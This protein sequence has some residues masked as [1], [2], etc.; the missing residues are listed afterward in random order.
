ML[1]AV[2]V[3]MDSIMKPVFGTP[4]GTG[5]GPIGGI[6]TQTPTAK[7]FGILRV[8]LVLVD[9]DEAARI[10]Q[11]LDAAHRLMPR[12]AGSIIEIAEGQFLLALRLA[13]LVDLL[14][15]I[16]PASTFLTRALVIHLMCL[17]RISTFQQPLGVAHAVQP[18]VADVGLGRDEG[19]RH[20]VAHL[21]RGAGRFPG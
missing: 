18:Q 21:A 20:A 12:K 14:D 11:P 16:V 7:M 10:G 17:S 3:T 15:V 5:V 8:P 19:H 2:A 6:A 9:E 1:W 13:V 4:H